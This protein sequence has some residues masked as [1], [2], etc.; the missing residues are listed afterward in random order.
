MIFFHDSSARSLRNNLQNHVS[1]SS[2]PRAATRP[3]SS[4]LSSDGEDDATE[5]G[6][7]LSTSGRLMWF[8]L[9]LWCRRDCHADQNT[10]MKIFQYQGEIRGPW[11]IWVRQLGERWYVP[12]NS[13]AQAGGASR[14]WGIIMRTKTRKQRDHLADD[15]LMFLPRMR[16]KVTTYGTLFSEDKDCVLVRLYCKQSLNSTSLRCPKLFN[17]CIF[18]ILRNSFVIWIEEL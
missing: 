5:T 15:D 9:Y 14:S 3:S 1:I 4:C 6:V 17:L 18:S 11:R 12:I 16:V 7:Y 8:S 13:A 10:W 2:W